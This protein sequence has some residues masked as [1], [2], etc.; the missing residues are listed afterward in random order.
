M[1]KRYILLV[2]DDKDIAQVMT[3]ILRND[4]HRIKVAPDI[5]TAIRLFDKEQPELILL[6]YLLPDGPIEKF[7]THTRERSFV[8]IILVTAATNGEAVAETLQISQLIKK[9]FDI[10]ELLNKVNR[11]LGRYC[12]PEQS[13]S[14]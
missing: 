10:E 14:P 2:E 1:M 7:V 8:P 4:G 3:L 11:C 6:D 13:I 5:K 9:P 12:P